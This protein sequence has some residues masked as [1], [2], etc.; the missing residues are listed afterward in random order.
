MMYFMNGYMV[1]CYCCI[2]DLILH[3]A[4]NKHQPI[5]MENPH[6]IANNN[7]QPLIEIPNPYLETLHTNLHHLY[8]V[9]K[10]ESEFQFVLLEFIFSLSS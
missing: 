1:T 5:I 2:F 8:I 3:V 7:F 9:Q 10:Q 4:E 6:A